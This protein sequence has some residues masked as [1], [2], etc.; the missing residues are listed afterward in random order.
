M[1]RQW[2]DTGREPAKR[3][4]RQREQNRKTGVAKEPE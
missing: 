4:E 2:R 1:H 3:K